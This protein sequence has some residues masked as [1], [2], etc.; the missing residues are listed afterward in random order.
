[1]SCSKSEFRSQEVQGSSLGVSVSSTASP[2]LLLEACKVICC[3]KLLMWHVGVVAH[4]LT[5]QLPERRLRQ[6]D[7]LSAGVQGHP[8][9]HCGTLSPKQESENL[10]SIRGLERWLIG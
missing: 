7:C 3:Q 9:Q 1:M 8:D 4:S 6:E 2:A 5:L 10:R